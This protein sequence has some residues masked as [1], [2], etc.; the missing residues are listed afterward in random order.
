MFSRNRRSVDPGKF[1]NIMFNLLF[2]PILSVFFGLHI[3]NIGNYLISN[4][5]FFIEDKIDG[6]VKNETENVYL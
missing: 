4:Q 3:V 6:M 1:K 5:S 2:K